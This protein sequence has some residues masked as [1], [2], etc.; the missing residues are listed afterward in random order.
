MK[1][2][3]KRVEKRRETIQIKTEFIKLDA[4]LKL[5]DAVQ[6]GGHAKL[7]VQDGAVRVNNEI[8]TQRGRKLR[9][10]DSVEFENVIYLVE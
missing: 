1:I 3:V 9:P 8:C 7:V 2:K 6:T 4:F 10:G 5:C